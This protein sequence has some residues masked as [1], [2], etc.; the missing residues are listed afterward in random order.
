MKR[1]FKI[2]GK[3]K[4]RKRYFNSH[5]GVALKHQTFQTTNFDGVAAGIQKQFLKALKQQEENT[6]QRF[7]KLVKTLKNVCIKNQRKFG[8]FKG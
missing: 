8:F 6:S 7:L 3:K 4:K 2:T 1:E 5:T